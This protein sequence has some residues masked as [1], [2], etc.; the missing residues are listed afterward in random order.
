VGAV[1]VAQVWLLAGVPALLVSLLLFLAR[2]Q[3]ANL[4]GFVV[5]AAGFAVLTSA[6]RASGAAFGALLALLYATGRGHVAEVAGVP[7]VM[8]DEVHDEGHGHAA[9]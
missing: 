4:L 8:P 7:D 2:S 1:T 9:A 5:L 6:D 3:L